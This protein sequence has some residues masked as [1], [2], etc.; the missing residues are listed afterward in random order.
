MSFVG[1][2]PAAG[3][4]EA[5]IKQA[6]FP[7]SESVVYRQRTR[8]GEA[9]GGGRRGDDDAPDGPLLQRP[10]A[11]QGEVLARDFSVPIDVELPS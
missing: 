5:E 8:V 4:H 9:G 10:S 2:P 6:N 11:R 3:E 7:G 1:R